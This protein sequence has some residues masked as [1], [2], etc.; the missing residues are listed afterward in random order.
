MAGVT[1]QVDGA[2]RLLAALANLPKEKMQA[3]GDEIE[4]AAFEVETA[5]KSRAPKDQGQVANSI[6]NK[7]TVS[8]EYM[9]EWEVVVQ[10]RYAPYIEFGTKT[11]AVIPAELQA[12]AAQYRVKQVSGLKAKEAIYAWA[13]RK[14]IDQKA[15]YLIYRSIMTNGIRPHPFF[16]TSWYAV[17]PKLIERIKQI[18]SE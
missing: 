11:K 16:Y 17:K 8:G 9:V 5:A 6:S 2:D 12:V 7:Q 15:W 3:I 18:V 4:A 1:I 13:R 14:G 10:A